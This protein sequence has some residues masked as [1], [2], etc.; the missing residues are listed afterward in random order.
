MAWQTVDIRAELVA[1]VLAVFVSVR[2]TVR[3]G[4]AMA[5][6]ESMKM[7][8]PLISEHEGVVTKVAVTAGDVVQA[9]E[10][11]VSIAIAG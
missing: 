10:I 7:E 9:G 11:V 1:T 6:L 4:D 8:I 2:D 5:L 3:S